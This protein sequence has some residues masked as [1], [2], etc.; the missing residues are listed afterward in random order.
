M[1][2]AL[3]IWASGDWTVTEGKEDEFVERWKAWLGWSSQN[4]PGF[5][6]ATLVRDT[7]DPRHFVS[8]S[9]WKDAGARDAWKNSDGFAEKFP[10]T[11]E[12]CDAFRGGDFELAVSF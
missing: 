6:S 12:L 1:A 3:Q 10:A 11:R 5:V 8:F 4:V 7:Q 9:S 2:D